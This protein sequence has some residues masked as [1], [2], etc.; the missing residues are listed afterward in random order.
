MENKL[1]DVQDAIDQTSAKKK[2]K[3]RKSNAERTEV[4]EILSVSDFSLSDE[5]SKKKKKRKIEAN[6]ESTEM[7]FSESIKKNKESRLILATKSV[8]CSGSSDDDSIMPPPKNVKSDKSLIETTSGQADT[9]ESENTPEITKSGTK[10][11]KKAEIAE[12]SLTEDYSGKRAK[13]SLVAEL[14]RQTLNGINKS[15]NMQISAEGMSAD[16]T[17]KKNWSL[18]GVAGA[19]SQVNG[20][21][22]KK[23]LSTPKISL[24]E[25]VPTSTKNP[26]NSVRKRAPK[27]SSNKE[28]ILEPHLMMSRTLGIPL[29]PEDLP[30]FP[31]N[32]KLK[33]KT[34]T[35][36]EIDD[37]LG[38]LIILNTN[39]HEEH[40]IENSI[41]LCLSRR[42]R[43]E[44]KKMDVIS[45]GKLWS[46]EEDAVLLKNWES[47]QKQ[48]KLGKDDWQVFDPKHAASRTTLLGFYRLLGLGLPKRSLQSISRRFIHLKMYGARK[49]SKVY[50]EEENNFIRYYLSQ[51]NGKDKFSRLANAI[52]RS[53]KSLRRHCEM[54]ERKSEELP[55]QS[56][57]SKETIAA[58]L[59]VAMKITQRP[60]IEQ[61]KKLKSLPYKNIAE[62]MKMC[63]IDIYRLWTR[64]LYHELR[65]ENKVLRDQVALDAVRAVQKQKEDDILKI[66]WKEVAR[67]VT[68]FHRCYLHNVVFDKAKRFRKNMSFRAKCELLEKILE[69]DIPNKKYTSSQ[70]IHPIKVSL[71]GDV[72][73]IS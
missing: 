60:T 73:K 4:H 39:V 15:V 14:E 25:K 16:S 11:K 53:R 1:V 51:Y 59:Q 58:F 21:K 32:D 43:E 19:T 9:K 45:D 69:Y 3:K 48:H 63:E 67:Q 24:K 64:H 44:L 65:L 62:Q 61:F 55:K 68:P 31:E 56:V 7:S 20:G 10:K 49:K 37:K 35:Q 17:K 28:D 29:E 52:G 2:K 42:T 30:S 33:Y 46:K 18:N 54:L 38:S 36:S 50:S 70:Y 40:M 41:S 66:S 72:V 71:E 12:T 47:F 26:S 57:N 5:G 27:K 23:S 22:I 6:E 8:D 13:K 34:L